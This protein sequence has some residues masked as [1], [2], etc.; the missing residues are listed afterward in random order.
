MWDGL[1]EV[2]NGLITIRLRKNTLTHKRNLISFLQ[3]CH[4]VKQSWHYCCHCQSISMSL[5]KCKIYYINGKI[6]KLLTN[7]CWWKWRKKSFWYGLVINSALLQLLIYSKLTKTI[8]HHTNVFI[9]CFFVWHSSI[10]CIFIRWHFRWNSYNNLISK[11]IHTTKHLNIHY[12][13][14]NFD[15]KY[16]KI[17]T[18]IKSKSRVASYLVTR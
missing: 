4:C 14:S 6:C 9:F 2:L 5:F 7:S 10:S 18:L 1:I 12:I 13:T 11:K 15:L 16:N 8:C 17:I 3:K